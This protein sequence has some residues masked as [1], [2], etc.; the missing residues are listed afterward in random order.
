MNKRAR[1][2]SLFFAASA[3][4]FASSARSQ[5]V[6][7]PDN[8]QTRV[9]IGFAGGN[10]VP[11]ASSTLGMRIGRIPRVSVA[12]RGSAVHID[13]STAMSVNL[14]VAVG[15]Y[16]GMTLAPTIGGFASIDLI[17][18]VGRMGLKDDAGFESDPTSWAIGAR[19]GILRESF[20]VPGVAVSA[21][22]RKIG[23]VRWGNATN[24]NEFTLAD[25]SV[26]SVRATIGKR[27][28]VFG[29]TA[30]VGYDRFASDLNIGAA[31][32]KNTR[33]T[34]FIDAT[35]TML[36]LNLVAEGGVQTGGDSPNSSGYFA[37]LAARLVL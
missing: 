13:P 31:V 5:T 36:V 11:G 20:T 4:F 17:G 30:G 35:W 33:R 3:L 12:A 9:G 14:D 10:P 21:T 7:A 25:N 26:T 22:Y 8:V 19:I 18:S 15:L 34:A 1:I 28:F 27:L 32:F 6:Q 37:S 29:A 2:I 16:S 24:I 23:D